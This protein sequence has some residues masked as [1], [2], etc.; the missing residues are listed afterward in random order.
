MTTQ[1][2][3]VA[4]I[5]GHR[6]RL[7]VLRT[8]VREV[9]GKDVPPRDLIVALHRTVTV[10]FRVTPKMLETLGV[11]QAQQDIINAVV[12]WGMRTLG[13]ETA[14]SQVYP[15]YLDHARKRGLAPLGLK[16]FKNRALAV[17]ADPSQAQDAP[18]IQPLRPLGW[19]P[20]LFPELLQAL[21]R[22][23]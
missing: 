1:P 2:R 15:M 21:E 19:Q 9:T 8:L 6:E 4:S 7:E 14:I 5:R 10:A 20:G 22:V 12:V 17:Y 16:R 3:A 18:N 11:Q 23:G 13:K